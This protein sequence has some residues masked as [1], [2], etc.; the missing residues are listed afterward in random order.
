[1]LALSVPL[2]SEAEDYR[3][4]RLGNG[5]GRGMLHLVS[6]DSTSR[7]SL[8]NLHLTN[9]IHALQPSAPDHPRDALLAFALSDRRDE[10][11]VFRRPQQVRVCLECGVE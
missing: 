10:R 11:S 2:D 9:N 8:T 7:G 4:Q 6:H 5:R 3:T 1:M